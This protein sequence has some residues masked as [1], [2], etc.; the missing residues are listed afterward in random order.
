MEGLRYNPS[1][2]LSA[3]FLEGIAVWDAGENYAIDDEVIRE[4]GNG[5]IRLF[6]SLSANINKD[7]L[8]NP[9]DWKEVSERLG[10]GDPVIGGTTGSLM[11]IDSAG[12]LQE[13]NTR[14]FWD[15]VAK[16]L[17]IGTNSP[18]ARTHIKGNGNTSGTFSLIVE[19]SSGSPIIKARDDQ[20]VILFSNSSPQKELN[21]FGTS[22]Q[23]QEQAMSSLAVA[24]IHW[25][26]TGTG[27]IRS[28]IAGD[29]E[30]NRSLGLFA[31]STAS[32]SHRILNV[33]RRNAVP[34]IVVQI[35]EDF[36]GN[37]DAVLSV[38]GLTA[39]NT[40]NVLNLLDSADA[41]LFRVRNDGK[42]SVGV[43]PYGSEFNTLGDIESVPS[44]GSDGFVVTDRIGGNRVRIFITGG[45]ITQEAA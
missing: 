33:Q 29:N 34:K 28:G 32:A 17:G 26:A 27:T 3:P 11:Y 9:A 12:K 36:L 4:D 25:R 10:V 1:A 42:V 8:T 37:F 21:I 31:G 22:W 23:T 35:G 30:T 44:G 16:E 15:D 38:R 2:S 6:T 13:D 39:D 40:D 14:L 7:P 5:D 43:T 18:T 19:N 45:V 41:I 20:R 24:P